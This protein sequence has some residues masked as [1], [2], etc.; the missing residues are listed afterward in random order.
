MAILKGLGNPAQGRTVALLP[1]TVLR[2]V[3]IPQVT[4]NPES[5]C[6]MPPASPL[7]SDYWLLTT[8][9]WKLTS[10]L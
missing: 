5:G 1:V 4:I 6:I 7:L 9:H 3:I 10:D 8:D 2:W